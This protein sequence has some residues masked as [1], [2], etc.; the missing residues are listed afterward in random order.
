MSHLY[1][2]VSAMYDIRKRENND[3]Q[4]T[5]NNGE[6]MLFS[7]YIERI[8]IFL[9][10]EFPLVM[11]CEPEHE[12]LLWSMRP[13]HL[14]DLTRIIPL[15]YEELPY[16][17]HFAKFEENHK[18]RPVKNL[19]PQKFTPLYHFM[20]NMKTLFVK[21]V[22]HMNPFSTE[23][24]S[25]M[26]IRLH[27]VYNLSVDEFTNI[28]NG[29]PNDR[30]LITQSTYTSNDEV[31]NRQE[32]YEWTRGKICA[33]LFIGC[34]DP[35]LR[36][37]NLC[38]TEFLQ[39]IQDGY[40]P[41]DEMIYSYIVGNHEDLFEPHVGDYCDVLRNLEYHRNSTHL[42]TAFLHKSFQYGK[43][44]YT[45]KICESVR[46][47]YLLGEKYEISDHNIY[48][49]WYYNYVACFWLGKYDE[50]VDILNE[51]Y[52]LV[53]LNHGLLCHLCGIYYF[54]REMISYLGNHQIMEKYDAI[55]KEYNS[56]K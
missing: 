34:K 33:G 21:T 9:E 37:C 50:C 17:C 6:F 41:T 2:I 36:F 46:V 11:F 12:T 42:A 44:Y 35:I 43:H 1:T 16:Y 26:D 25:W 22:T 4:H 27:D 28:M 31:T 48:C 47:G 56:E 38:E 13:K 55:V 19:H 7:E 5:K 29:L 15:A 53:R 24:F 3:L 54:F 39:C 23:M 45:H 30:V 49:V 52:E 18:L 14:H 40:S 8:H 32:Y 51:Y 20:V 10:K